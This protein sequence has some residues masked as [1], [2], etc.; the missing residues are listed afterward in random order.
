MDDIST[1]LRKGSLELAVLTLLSTQPRYGVE[2]VDDLSA[3]P[4]LEATSGTIYPLLTRL[5]NSGLVETTWQESPV[6]PPRKYY[7]LSPA[8]QAQLASQRT[9][10]KQLVH[11]MNTLFEEA[12]R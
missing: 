11:A 6:G 9:A 12:G 7:R 1:Q 4:G 3:R 8:G 10:W 5:K 2:V